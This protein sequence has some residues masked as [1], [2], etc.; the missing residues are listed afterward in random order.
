MKKTQ[1]ETQ[2]QIKGL[3]KSKLSIPKKSLFGD[4]NHGAIDAQIAVLKGERTPNFYWVDETA[5]EYEDGD[6]D[7]FLA[8]D[9]ADEWMNG[10]VDG[11]LFDEE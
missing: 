2:A 7:I 3:E 1:E 11:N 9:K 6:N 4:D 10:Q 5:E 8:A